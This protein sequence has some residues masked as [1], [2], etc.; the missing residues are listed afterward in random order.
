LD[1]YI[2]VVDFLSGGEFLSKINPGTNFHDDNDTQTTRAGG[3][4]DTNIIDPKMDDKGKLHCPICDRVFNSRESYIS[5]ALSKH[6]TSEPNDA[7][8]FLAT[9]PYS[10]GFHFFISEG[11]YTG[12]TAVSLATFA[13]QVEA[14]PIESIDFHFKRAD[15][16]KWIT[17]TIGD[18]ELATAI[19]HVEKEL[20][21]EPLKRR[22]LWVINARVKE[23]E[24]Q[25]QLA[26]NLGVKNNQT[27]GLLVRCD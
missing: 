2:V 20:A 23:L 1:R 25:I 11:R 6:Q 7:R 15:F 22:L 13:R 14:A 26:S 24:N 5:H 18:T 3:M 21:G 4:Q 16:Q 9:V 27:D 12:E 17:D 10:I 19:G 8:K